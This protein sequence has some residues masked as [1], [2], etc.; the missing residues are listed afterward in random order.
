M[1]KN[2]FKTAWR[3]ILKDK[4]YS[5]LNIL[6]LATGM[7]VA[8]IIGLWVNFQF[9]YD[10]FLPNNS[11][12]YQAQYRSTRNGDIQ[13]QMATSLLLAPTLKQ[14]IP[15][16]QYVAQTD[17]MGEHGLVAGDK[18]LYIGGAHA[19][20]DF[21]KIFQYPL[22]QGN[23]ANALKDPNSIVLT[24]ATAIALFGKDDAMGKVVK[25]DNQ[26]NLKVTGVLDDVPGNSTLQFKFIIPFSQ[27]IQAEQWVKEA[28]TTWDNNSFQTFVQL[29][30]GVTL[31][32]VQT[33]LK[34]ISKRFP[35]D[36]AVVKPEVFLHPMTSWHLWSEFKN[37]IVV[38]GFI[39]YVRMF[40]IIGILVLLIACINF[41]NLS[42]ARS[43][44]RAREVGVRK[45]V[46]SL[47]GQLIYQFLVESVVITFIASAF[48]LLIVLV[49]LPAF[50]QLT[51]DAVSIPWANPFFWAILLG[52]S[53]LTGLLAGS[54]PA[55]YLSSFQPVKVLKGALQTGKGSS[56]PRKV[57]VVLQFSCSIGLI[58]GTVIVYQQIQHAK[59][60]PI[61][62]NSNRLVITDG[63]SDI[64]KN[65]TAIKS[66]LLNSGAVTS[67]TKASSSITGLNS[68]RGIDDWQ[69]KYPN[70]VLGMATVFIH[71]DYFSTTGM[72]LKE[73]RNFTGNVGADSLDMIL[74]EAAVKRYRFKNP[75]NQV[76][77]WNGKQMHS[78]VIGVVK[79]ALMM[80]PFSPAEPTMFI[81][82]PEFTYN[83]M[84]RLSPTANTH[85]ALD[86]VAA[87][88][89]KYNPSYP[90]IYHFADD[91][92][93]GK[94][95]F[96]VLVGK[97]A[98]IFAALA[99]FISCLGLF[100]LA[101][102]VA[103][104]RTKEIGIR[105]VLGASVPQLWMMLSKDFMVLVLISCIIASPVAWY[106]LSN[107]LLKY[108]YRI[109][110]GPA[111]FIYSALAALLITVVTISFQAIKA[112]VANPVRS[113]KSE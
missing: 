73:G 87:V 21:L 70:E 48:S 58:I 9:S 86:K 16:I 84:Y 83:V 56:W 107:W 82:R 92:Y 98:G 18:K 10:R 113:L 64:D 110:I 13:T 96:E 90:F 94:F 29:Q 89:N 77:T 53:L 31:A 79:D 63:S 2:Y 32:Q 88:F 12:V 100:G 55:F 1:L 27:Y 52:Y 105:K 40:S 60:R 33:K 28:S 78:R 75:I 24:K 72:Q 59:D 97:L 102:Y 104:Q 37:G 17:W 61:G 71:D 11:Q 3:N 46:G 23:A 35:P 62:Y 95:S 44:R 85:A 5:V 4:G 57:L 20:E 65:Y 30:P 93:A 99:I 38:G 7:A 101:A 111:V 50:N 49:A 69:G 43:E 54:R 51:G 45:A 47:R 109:T 80:S 6:G 42:T 8:L 26:F 14:D 112:A 39:D 106:F 81:Y 34:G 22:L 76:I 19:G 103:Q 41:T 91:N 68:W 67:V 15:E 108:D 36:W 74:N 66:S 25:V